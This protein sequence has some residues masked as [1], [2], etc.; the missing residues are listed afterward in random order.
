M[1]VPKPPRYHR[2]F[3]HPGEDAGIH[4]ARERFFHALHR[5]EPR[6]TGDLTGEPLMLY[7][8]IYQAWRAKTDRYTGWFLGMEFGS[9]PGWSHFEYAT[10]RDPES[11][12]WLRDLLLKWSRKWRLTDGWCLEAAVET[13]AD[14]SAGDDD[15]PAPRPLHYLGQRM[16]ELP[17]NEDALRFTFSRR[18]WEPT[19]ESWGT[20]SDRLTDAF[21][22]ELAAYRERVERQA[23]DAGLKPPRQGRHRKGDHLEWLAR[24]VVGYEDVD[25]IVSSS[26]TPLSRQAVEQAIDGAAARIGLTIPERQAPLRTSHAT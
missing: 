18:G 20:A 13:L 19:L 9:L 15:P 21:K 8:P 24:Y 7:R 25:D 10:S 6:V 11:H 26:D 22:R 17:F 23:K 14:L 12:R 3:E 5:V 16:V 2:A 1:S 4:E